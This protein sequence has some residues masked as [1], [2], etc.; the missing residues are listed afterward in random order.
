MQRPSRLRGESGSLT[1]DERQRTQISCEGTKMVRA[2]DGKCLARGEMA[3]E[4]ARPTKAGSM[5]A[6]GARLLTSH[7]EAVWRVYYPN[8]LPLICVHLR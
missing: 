5:L 3:R 8:G 1:A 4:D 2:A 7:R 6:G